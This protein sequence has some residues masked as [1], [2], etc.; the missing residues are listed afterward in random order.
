[1]ALTLD[2]SRT[3]A[4]VHG[5]NTDGIAFVQDGIPFDA[6]GML[7]DDKVPDD[8]KALVAQKKK[9]AAKL[10]RQN[11]QPPSPPEGS[12]TG[13]ADD[14]PDDDGE[15]DQ[16][17]VNFEAWLKDEV[18]YQPHVLFAAARKRFSK[19]FTNYR[20]LAEFLVLEE[21]VVGIDDVPTKL[22]VE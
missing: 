4:T 22:K 15:P 19:T 6:R 11:D 7:L 20:D 14:D 18:K 8:K 12:P 16:T 10:A 3:F 13:G 1:M 5:E 17:D 2:R 9:K 21:N